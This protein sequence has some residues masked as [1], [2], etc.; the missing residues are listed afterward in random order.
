MS[1]WDRQIEPITQWPEGVRD[2]LYQVLHAMGHRIDSARE[3]AE[4][5]AESIARER[6]L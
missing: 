6:G 2:R 5:A 3:R 1:I 4:K